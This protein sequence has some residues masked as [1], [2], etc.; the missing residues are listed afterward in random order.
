M[1]NADRYIVGLKE[2]L[3]DNVTEYPS[4]INTMK[5]FNLYPEVSLI[6]CI[7]EG[8]YNNLPLFV[9]VG[10]LGPGVPHL[11]KCSEVIGYVWD[12]V[13]YNHQRS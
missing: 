4:T 6:S 2:L 10:G 8:C 1:V 3:T 5:R 11:L 7:I 9:C 12:A 13:L